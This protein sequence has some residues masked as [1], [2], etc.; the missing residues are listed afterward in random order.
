MM[1]AVVTT[2]AG[3]LL[4][5]IFL[6]MGCKSPGETAAT[7]DETHFAKNPNGRNDAWGFAGYGGGGAMF[8]PAVSPF[9]SNYAFVACDMTGS[10]VTYNGGES[11]RMFNLRGPVH[12][13]IFDPLDSNTVYANSIALFKSTDKGNTWN[14]LYP[15]PG[16]IKRIISKGDHA[17]EVVVTNDS[18]DRRVLSFA[19]DP[20]DSKKLYAVIAI[21]GNIALHISGDGGQTWT[22]EK[23]LQDKVKN[24]Y[25]NPSSPKENR[26]IYFAGTN[27][28]QVKENGA[29][30]TNNGPAGLKK[31]TEF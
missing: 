17:T 26:T 29:W 4:F 19:I 25:I 24:I 14:V 3:F 20:A 13:F 7:K 21:D 9:N 18:T 1:K 30:K 6:S 28:I 10:F 2:I 15:A 11:W 22:K 31:L 8:Y 27:S 5:S 23:E 12:F 16:D